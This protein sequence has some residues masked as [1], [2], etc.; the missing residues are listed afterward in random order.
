M[1]KIIKRFIPDFISLLNAISGIIA[2]IFAISNINYSPF[3]LYLSVIFDYLDGKLAKLLKVKGLWSQIDSFADTI[4]FLIAP[5]VIS[6]ITRHSI[7][8]GII[9]LFFICSG[10]YRLYQFS[11]QENK[12][13]FIGM[14]V[15][16]NG[17]LFPLFYL[18]PY[19]RYFFILSGII[20][21][22]KIKFRKLK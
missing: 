2:I 3:I 1:E 22:I 18:T 12:T 6:S 19:Y 20:M 15:T 5:I 8:D 4:S 14:P 16:M 9:Y 13:Y 17:L 21:I 11:K 10:I 7:I